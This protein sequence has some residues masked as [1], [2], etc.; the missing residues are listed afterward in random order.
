MSYIGHIRTNTAKWTD[1]RVRLAGEA[2]SGCL[3]VKMLGAPRTLAC[4]VLPRPTAC[5]AMQLLPDGLSTAIK[6]V[7]MMYLILRL[8]EVLITK[9]YINILRRWLTP[10]MLGI[11]RAG[12]SVSIPHSHERVDGCVCRV[13]GRHGESAEAAAGQ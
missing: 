9:S 5:W 4:C 6:E 2:I 12:R 3:A 1:E 13:G 11:L 7:F 10:R 8:S